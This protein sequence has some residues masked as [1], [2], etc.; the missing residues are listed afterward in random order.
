M[1]KRLVIA[2]MVFSSLVAQAGTLFA[3][4]M[5]ESR[6]SQDCCCDDE[7]RATPVESADASPC[8]DEIA[9]VADDDRGGS[10]SAGLQLPDVAAHPIGRLA[11]IDSA[12]AVVR[13]S[14][15]ARAPPASGSR[16]FLQ[17]HRLRI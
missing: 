3:C 6:V 12:P 16:I 5:M 7:V 14:H 11:H 8:C 10:A 15:H 2:V 1:F 4:E 13:S 9:F 17:T